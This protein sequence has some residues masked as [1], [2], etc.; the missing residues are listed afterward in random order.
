ML[1]VRVRP[2][3]ATGALPFWRA[4]FVIQRTGGTLVGYCQSI[5]FR[6]ALHSFSWQ[7]TDDLAEVGM[8]QLYT[9][10]L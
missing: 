3:H 9:D 4:K 7:F 5:T 8:Y 1:C 10:L 2:A 6:I